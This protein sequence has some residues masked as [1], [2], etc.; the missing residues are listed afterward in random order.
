[1]LI[2]IGMITTSVT[3]TCLCAER[4]TGVIVS[5]IEAYIP[6]SFSRPKPSKPWVNTAYLLTALNSSL[7]PLLITLPWTIPG[8]FLLLF[9]PLTTSCYLLKFFVMMFSMPSLA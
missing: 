6:H 2:F 3:E 1:M 8:L 9:P 7:K 5:G 4:I